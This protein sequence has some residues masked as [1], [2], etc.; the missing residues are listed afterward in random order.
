MHKLTF[1][2]QQG[3]ADAQ[4]E[5]GLCLYEGIGV[6]KDMYESAR[7]Y[8][9]AAAQGASQLGNSWIW[10]PKYD[11]YCAAENAA[12]TIG[13]TTGTSSKK[14]SVQDRTKRLSNAIQA[15]IH[16]SSAK[17]NNTAQHSGSGSGSGVDGARP[18]SHST[19]SSLTA[20]S[21]PS[22]PSIPNPHYSISMIASGLASVTATT[23]GTVAPSG[24]ANSLRQSFASP[25]LSATSI[26]SSASSSS[27]ASLSSPTSPTSPVSSAAATPPSSTIEWPDKK[28]SRWSIWGRSAPT[29]AS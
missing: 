20:G 25:H 3:D 19:A 6:D 13:V 12:A 24:Y 18:R 21:S 22:S 15:A 28:K 1:Q 10:K 9:M 29:P 4:N 8:R 11:Q 2:T 27:L 14:K 7:Y 17:N 26:A 16:G 23:T 5:T